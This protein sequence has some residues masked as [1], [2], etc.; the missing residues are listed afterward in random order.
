[1]SDRYGRIEVAGI[2]T[3][4]CGVLVFILWLPTTNYYVLIVFALLSGA[5]LG[6]F[7][8]VRTSRRRGSFVSSMC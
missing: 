8:A 5:I 4:S 2:T 6:I 7:W 1:M 3:F